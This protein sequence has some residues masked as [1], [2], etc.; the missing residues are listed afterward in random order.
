MQGLAGIPLDLVLIM[1]ALIIV[2]IAAPELV[3]SI[4][5]LKAPEGEEG[6]QLTKGWGG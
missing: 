5:R 1:Q 6:L 3:R 2:F 4:Y